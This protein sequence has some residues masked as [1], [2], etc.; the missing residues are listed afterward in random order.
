LSQLNLVTL[1]EIRK[2]I[3]K[4]STLLPGKKFLT[5]RIVEELF[6][7]HKLE[8]STLLS[9]NYLETIKALISGGYAWGVL[10]EIMLTDNSLIKLAVKNRNLFRHLDCIYHKE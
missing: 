2:E 6:H 10:P 3:K 1:K 8:V 5:T 9:T 7:K 4:Y